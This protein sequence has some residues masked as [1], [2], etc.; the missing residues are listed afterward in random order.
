MHFEVR[1]TGIGIPQ[2][3]LDKLFQPFTQADS[4]TT[5]RFG[6]TGL[7]LSISRELSRLLGGEIK[8]ASNPGTG[9]TFWFILPVDGPL[10]VQ[11]AAAPWPGEEAH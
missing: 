7:G 2:D 11:A 5:R 6:G 8:L 3:S 4:S 9:S 10:S 1:D